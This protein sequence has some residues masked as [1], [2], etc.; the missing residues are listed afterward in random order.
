M[1]EQGQD[2][3]DRPQY[4]KWFIQEYS[5]RLEGGFPI[6]CYRLNYSIDE[7][8]L[9]N[10]ALHI[11]RHYEPDE[12]LDESLQDTEMSKEEYL[13]EYVIPQQKETLGPTSRSND[14]TEIMISDILEFIYHFKVPRCKQQNRSGKTKSEH[15]S[16]IIAYKIL[17]KDII[18]N[19]LDE[20]LVVEVKA[21]LTKSSYNAIEEA[22]TDSLK[23][24]N[25]RYAHTLNFYRKKLKRI[26]KKNEALEVARFQKK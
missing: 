16:D 22:L 7:E 6:E 1:V 26:N 24:D 4:I 8:V 12:E 13:R 15:D 20:L 23:Y 17:D 9:D 11:R 19:N 2:K 5:V 25:V 3:M 18:A 21:T 14:I 10:W